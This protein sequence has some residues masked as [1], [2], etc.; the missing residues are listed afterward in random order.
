MR[1]DHIKKFD[2][3]LDKDYYYA[4]EVLKGCIVVEN[5]ENL[6]VRG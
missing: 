6:K 5:V 4:G 2:I 3:E 1:M